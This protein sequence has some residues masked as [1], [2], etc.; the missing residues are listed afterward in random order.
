MLEELPPLGECCPCPP[1]PLLVCWL[2][3]DLSWLTL[4]LISPLMTG[5]PPPVPPCWV[6][7]RPEEATEVVAA[8]PAGTLCVGSS[9][10]LVGVA[11][12]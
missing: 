6:D 5:S 9:F 10:L 7:L 4:Q 1:W 3:R 12:I 8:M 11:L 2:K